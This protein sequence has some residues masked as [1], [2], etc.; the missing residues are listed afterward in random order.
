MHA[1]NLL[2]FAVTLGVVAAFY[3]RFIA[4]D[5]IAG[6]ALVLFALDD[7]HGPAVGWVAKSIFPS[8]FLSGAVVRLSC[9]LA[10]FTARHTLHIS[11][12]KVF[13]T[14]LS[15]VMSRE[16]FAIMRPQP[17]ACT[18]SHCAPVAMNHARKTREIWQRLNTG[19]YEKWFSS[20]RQSSFSITG[21]KN[22]ILPAPLRN[23]PGTSGAEQLMIGAKQRL[24][25]A[26]RRWRERGPD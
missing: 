19:H 3:R 7:A 23:L 8:N 14:A 22:A 26:L 25:P 21:A 4:S 16:W 13:V 15:R 11:P 18:K 1:Q 10:A 17:K 9:C 24:R 5:W 6:L 12:S 2:W 20:G